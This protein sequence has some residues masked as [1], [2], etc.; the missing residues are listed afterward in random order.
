MS[1]RA[2]AFGATLLSLA[3]LAAGAADAGGPLVVRSNGAPFA[4]STASAVIYRTDNG[5]LSASV[6][7]STARSRV[8]GM[9]DVWENVPTSSISYARATTSAGNGAGFIGTAGAFNG[10]DV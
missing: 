9:F 6:G 10:G 7:E 3:F 1:G 5:P 4:W 2:S 8:A